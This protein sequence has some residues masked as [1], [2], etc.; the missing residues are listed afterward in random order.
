MNN[1]LYNVHPMNMNQ[2]EDAT[3][4]E[5]LQTIESKEDI[6]QRHLA[7]KLDVALGLANSYLKRCVT[8]GLIKVKQAPP[9]RYFYYLTPK[10]FA[11]KSRLTVKYLTSSFDFYRNA[12]S[13]CSDIFSNC[14]QTGQTRILLCGISELAEIASVRSHYHTIN[15]IGIYDRQIS[16]PK[17]LDMPMWNKLPVEDSYDAIVITALENT[18]IIYDSLISEIARDKIFVPSILGINTTSN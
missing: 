16:I 2:K 6:T 7:D 9:N 4:L 13:A 8:K 3:T 10:G 1:T 5:I 15:I 11:E 12:G 18:Q 14:E 17:F